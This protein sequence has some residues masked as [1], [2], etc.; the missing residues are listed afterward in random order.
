MIVVYAE[1]SCQHLMH[2]GFGD[3]LPELRLDE[4]SN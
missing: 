1:K 4:Q 3:H 2:C